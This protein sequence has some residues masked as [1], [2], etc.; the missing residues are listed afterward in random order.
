MQIDFYHAV[1]Y[2]V[3]RF[4][5]FDQSQSETIAYSSQYVDDATNEGI[6]NFSNGARYGRIATAHKMLD[7]RNIDKLKNSLVWT[8][9]NF[10]PGNNGAEAG[11]NVDGSFVNKLVCRHNSPVANDMLKEC[12]EDKHRPYALHRVGI[13]SHVFVDTWGPQ[14]FAKIKHRINKVK[15]IKDS[16]KVQ[17][18]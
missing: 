13:T 10:L 11:E 3:S 7:Y 8:S 2:V 1:I 18:I 15:D 5:E 6:I 4:S 9:F 14:G 16:V 12:I 17:V